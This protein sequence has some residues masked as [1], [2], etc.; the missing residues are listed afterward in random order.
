VPDRCGGDSNEEYLRT[1]IKQQEEVK[2]NFQ[3][4]ESAFKGI[5]LIWGEG[6]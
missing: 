3:D 1:G 5:L 2:L 4:L 6:R